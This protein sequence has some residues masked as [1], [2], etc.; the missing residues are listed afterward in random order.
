MCIIVSVGNEPYKIIRKEVIR[1]RKMMKKEITKTTVKVAQMKSENG[2]PTAIPLEDEILLGNVTL[3]KAQ[4][5]VA[6][7][8]DEPVSV[9]EVSTDTKVYQMP[10]SEF[11]K[12]A[13]VEEKDEQEE[14][15]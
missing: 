3:E 6:K 9:F 2:L 4:M 5:I 12:V 10:V 13:D 11:V 1:M 14:E 7:K 8:Y 15:Q